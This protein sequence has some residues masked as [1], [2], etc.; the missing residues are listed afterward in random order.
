MTGIKHKNKEGGSTMKK[1]ADNAFFMKLRERASLEL[2]G[3]P[4]VA[5]Y[6]AAATS[7]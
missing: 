1:Y 6:L 3:Y 4:Q 2:L 5:L 7:Y